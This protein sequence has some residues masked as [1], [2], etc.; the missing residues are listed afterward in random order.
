[1]AI[2]GFGFKKV[3]IE[4]KAFE[5]GPISP[6]SSSL[7]INIK[8]I[9]KLKSTIKDKEILSFEF[10]F[11]IK[12]LQNKKEIAILSFEGNV[13]YLTD[14]AKAEKILSNWTKK[15]IE[16]DLKLLILNTIMTKC[17]LKALQFEEDLNLPLHLKL[18]H[19]K[20][21]I[22]EEKSDKK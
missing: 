6:I 21:S 12:Y 10:E 3:L 2:F 22:K 9:T 1:M 4:R 5:Q 11:A 14:N 20:K 7:N 19:F 13:L 18:P 17:N 15:N 8:E 16:E